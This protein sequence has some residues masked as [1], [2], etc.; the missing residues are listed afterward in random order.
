MGLSFITAAGPRQRSHSRAR[1]SFFVVSDQGLLQP[2]RSGPCIYIPQVTG[3]P[4]YTPRHWVLFSTPPTTRRAMVEIFD[5]AST[6]IS[7]RHNS[8]E[9]V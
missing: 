3:R 7:E 6:R 9:R 2:R 1:D 4:N 8:V 5:P